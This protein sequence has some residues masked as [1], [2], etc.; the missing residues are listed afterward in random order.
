MG[1]FGVSKV[2]PTREDFRSCGVGGSVFWGWTGRMERPTDRRE[3][4]APGSG[5]DSPPAL[6]T[7]RLR[8]LGRHVS[9]NARVSSGKQPFHWCSGRSPG[10]CGKASW[11]RGAWSSVS[12]VLLSLHVE[13]VLV[14]HISHLTSGGN[15][16]ADGRMDLSK[17]EVSL[18]L[19][20]KFEGL[21]TDAD[22]TGARSLLLR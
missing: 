18:T 16:G 21:E 19:T 15:V 1:L 20:N 3:P 9:S 7:P 6:R 8:L 17:L 4:G 13:C 14:P 5:R 11:K 2:S 22:D 10:Q 12:T